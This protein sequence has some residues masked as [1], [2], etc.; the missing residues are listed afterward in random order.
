MGPSQ[1][2]EPKVCRQQRRSNAKLHDDRHTSH[3]HA[4]RDGQVVAL[5][6]L[7]GAQWREL[8]L[9][10]FRRLQCGQLGRNEHR[11]VLAVGRSGVGRRGAERVQAAAQRTS[12]TDRSSRPTQHAVAALF[13]GQCLHAIART[14]CFDERRCAQSRPSCRA[15]ARVTHRRGRARANR[16]VERSERRG[17]PI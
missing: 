14:L 2:G 11:F 13:R 3:V 1:C 4:Q 9:C 6:C 17:Q 5:P 15:I 16:Y 7:R 12:G 8:A 10:Q